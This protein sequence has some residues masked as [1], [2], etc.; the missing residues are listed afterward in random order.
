MIQDFIKKYNIKQIYESSSINSLNLDM[1]YENLYENTIFYG[2]YTE[3]DIGTILNHRGK[4]W[5]LWAG[6]DANIKYKARLEIINLMKSQNIESHLVKDT[7]VEQNL[8][9][10]NVIPINI[11][12]NLELLSKLDSFLINNDITQVIVSAAIDKPIIKTVEIDIYKDKEA[13]TL[14][15]GIYN[16]FDISR[17]KSHKGKKW[18]LWAGNDANIEFKQRI[19]VIKAVND[20]KL[21]NILVTNDS[22][23][24]NMK[25]LGYDVLNIEKKYKLNI[26]D[27]ENIQIKVS[28]HI[29]N[30]ENKLVKRY[31]LK[32][33]KS[34]NLPTLFVGLY[35][36]KDV[37]SLNAHKGTKYLLWGGKDTNFDVAK[38]KFNLLGIENINDINHIAFCDK[39][40]S[41]LMNQYITSKIIK[42]DGIDLLGKSDLLDAKEENIRKSLSTKFDNSILINS[43]SNLNLIAGDTIWMSNLCN[44]L[45]CKIT[46]ITKYELTNDS[47][48]KNIENPDNIDIKIFDNIV[49]F[50][51]INIEKF[52]S[53]IIRNNEL[54]NAIKN[55]GWLNKTTIYGLDVHLNGVKNLNNKFKELW[56]QS[57]KLKQLFIDNEI[58]EKKNSY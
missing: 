16:I 46:I 30:F 40:Y 3:K 1:K 25:S 49:D 55:K 22:N 58:N 24:N 35:D 38:F 26:Q 7:N 57:E 53:I 42:L 29:T 20:L 12:N 4:K 6:Q 47:F 54:L 5:I 50:I 37:I 18:V 8:L 13:N 17:I 9:F 41:N 51:D 45:N 39:I 11:N 2:V 36:L 31:N 44:T 32:E 34:K 43:S 15:Y 28:S 52:D 10:A 48:I 56:T 14:F 21:E 33:Y 23:E 27:I 19:N